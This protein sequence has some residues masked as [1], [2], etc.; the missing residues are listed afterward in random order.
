[1]TTRPAGRRRTTPAGLAGLVACAG[2]IGFAGW[3]LGPFG[4]FRWGDGASA[5]SIGVVAAGVGLSRSWR[6]AVAV[7][8]M[9]VLL[10]GLAAYWASSFAWNGL[11][12]AA[13]DPGPLES[14]TGLLPW[15]ALAVVAAS[16]EHVVPLLRRVGVSPAAA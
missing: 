6:S 3:A 9:P 11:S 13:L 1:M 15:L 12:R 16:W 7:L 8:L 4:L 14:L 5:V 10:T 2:A